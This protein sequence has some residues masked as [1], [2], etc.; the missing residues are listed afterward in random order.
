MTTVHLMNGHHHLLNGNMNGAINGHMA[1]AMNG[2]PNHTQIEQPSK[3][4]I[5]QQQPLQQVESEVFDEESATNLIIN[6]LPQ[7]MTEE[8]LRTLFSSVG[9][10]ESCKLIRDKVC[11]CFLYTKF[12]FFR[13]G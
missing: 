6:Y 1:T 10:L 8:E 5:Q 12:C 13:K 4:V 2:Y 11:F 3:T 7:E 9:P